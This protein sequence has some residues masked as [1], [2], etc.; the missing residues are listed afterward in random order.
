MKGIGAGS[1]RSYWNR[2]WPW[3]APLIIVITAATLVTGNSHAV[4]Y[5]DAQSPAAESAKLLYGPLAHTF[6]ARPKLV[7]KALIGWKKRVEERGPFWRDSTLEF[8]LRSFDFD[9]RNSG[10]DEREAW[11]I[12]GQLA[13]ESGRWHNF[14]VRAAF[15]NSTE[16]SASGGDTGVLLPGQENINVFGEANVSYEL[17]ATPLKGS[18]I[19][20]YRQTFKAPYL[21]TSDIRMLPSTHE[22]YVISRRDSE[23]DYFVGH[24]T[25]FKNYDSDKFVHMSEAAGADGSNKGVT[26]LGGWLPTIS[27]KVSIGVGTLYGWDTFNTLFAEGSYFTELGNGFDMRLST[28]FTGQ[29]SVGDELVGDFKTH[30]ASARAAFGWRG[31]VLKIAGSKTSDDA[32]IRK[33]W[34]GSPSYL[35][36]MRGDF[37]RANEKGLLVGLS[38][39]SKRLGLSGYGNIAWGSEAEDPATAAPLPDRVEYDLTL[40]W[41]PPSLPLKGLWLRARYAHVDNDGDGKTVDDIRLILNYGIPFF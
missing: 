30:H 32:A 18:A 16:L 6:R 38:Y 14:G 25:K 23:L 5:I 7:R 31:A 41:K 10:T 22:G 12:G 36:L 28:Q 15:Y 3:L 2:K 33:P 37:D 13:Y 35:A 21:N 4:E 1:T 34:G 11:A 39:N 40:D 8:D 29:R 19:R 9:R 20:L 27:E 26:A 24:I 17:D